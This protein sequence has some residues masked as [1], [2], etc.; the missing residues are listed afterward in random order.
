MAAVLAGAN[1]LQSIRFAVWQT[2]H[3]PIPAALL[4]VSAATCNI[5]LSLVAV[6][7]LHLGGLGRI[8]GATLATI[9]VGL[10]S[11][12]SLRRE[13]SL[14][15]WQ[16]NHIRSL[17]RF[18]V[19]LAPH[20]MAAAVMASADR[21]A[22]AGVL[23]ASSLGVYGT[24]AQLGSILTVLADAATKAYSPHMYQLLSRRTLRTRLRVVGWA[25]LSVIGWGVV[26]VCLWWSF[27]LSAPLLLGAEY[28]DAAV[29]LASWFLAG[30][31]IGAVYLQVAGLFFFSGRTEWI[32]MASSSAALVAMLLAGPLV[33][34]WGLVGGG[35]L[36]V[37]AQLVLLFSALLLSFRVN[38]MPWNHPLLA[39]RCAQ[40][41]RSVP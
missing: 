14:A 36:F 39:L 26:A 13:G 9:G 38:P 25:Y 27:H 34:A 40:P 3:R 12:S 1:V 22:V 32:S 35:V 17:L 33:R 30:A 5:V 19:P 10:F 23:G 24:A 37:T 28:R 29:G 8:A 16:S 21:F 18:G 15:P 4:Q 20:A 2:Q 41:R 7:V 6:F 11:I 31:A